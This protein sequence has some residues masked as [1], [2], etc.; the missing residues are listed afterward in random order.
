MTRFSLMDDTLA[1]MSYDILMA[2][3]GLM[4]RWR[5]LSQILFL[6]RQ[7]F[8]RDKRVFV[9]VATKHVF[10]RDKSMLAA[11]KLFVAIKLCLS[12]QNIFVATKVYL[13]RQTR[14]CRDKNDTCGSSRQ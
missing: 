6:P 2:M 7:K 1:R 3:N 14:V 4:Y 12:R 8:R 5:E 13:S 11:T 10:C 9:F